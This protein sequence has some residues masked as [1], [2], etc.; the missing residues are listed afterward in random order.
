VRSETDYFADI[1][2]M[3]LPSEMM[4]LARHIIDTKSAY[5]DASMLKDHHRDAIVRII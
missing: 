3:K 2:E 4:K 1:P 5:F